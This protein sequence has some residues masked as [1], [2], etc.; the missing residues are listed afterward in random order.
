M[1][2]SRALCEKFGIVFERRHLHPPSHRAIF[3]DIEILGKTDYNKYSTSV[4]IESKDKPWRHST[5]KR[6]EIITE[7]AIR[8]LDA[9][10]NE[11][12]WRL[13]LEPEILSRFE[14][15]VTCIRCRA[16]LWRSELEAALTV[17]DT[18][19]P[20][21][22]E[23]RERRG[24]CS[25]PVQAKG[26]ER[27]D[28]GLNSI[29]DDRADELI[30]HDPEI[31]SQLPG[32][33]KPDRVYGFR[34]TARFKRLLY[35]T[36]SSSGTLI[37]ESVKHSPFPNKN[38]NEPLLF[39]FLV[40]EA[41]SE[42]GNGSFTQ[43][44]TQTAFTIRTLLDLQY[45][46]KKASGPGSQW[47][48]EP[49]VWFIGY[50]GEYWRISAAYVDDQVV[51]H[52]FRIIDGL[53]DGR[54]TKEEDSLR[55][56]LIMDYIFDW[57][58]D[59]H[60]RDI[61]EGLISLAET[62]APSLANETDVFSTAD[63]SDFT[64]LNLEPLEPEMA[65]ASLATSIEMNKA[66]SFF[67]GHGYAIR[68]GRHMHHTFYGLEV[69]VDNVREILQL[70]KSP[71]KKKEV[72][73]ALRI[74]SNHHD[75]IRVSRSCIDTIES[76]W[77]GCDRAYTSSENPLE[78]LQ[79][80]MMFTSFLGDRGHGLGREDPTVWDHYHEL[81]IVAV[82]DSA[83]DI[84]G[85]TPKR[86]P[87][88]DE[89]GLIRLVQEIK[90]AQVVEKLE[91]AATCWSQSISH[92]ALPR[93]FS[94]ASVDGNITP[95]VG[96][97]G[98]EAILKP[99]QAQGLRLPLKTY[100]SLR[101]GHLQHEASFMRVSRSSDGPEISKTSTHKL[102]NSTLET[103]GNWGFL[104]VVKV[105]SVAGSDVFKKRC[106]YLLDSSS[107]M[108]SQNESHEKDLHILD[109]GRALE[110]E[111]RNDPIPTKIYANLANLKRKV[112]A[113]TLDSNFAHFYTNAILLSS[114]LKR[115]TCQNQDNDGQ[116]E[117][118]QAR[119]D[120]M[121]SDPKWPYSFQETIHSVYQIGRTYGIETIL[122]GMK[123]VM[124][125]E[126]TLDESAYSVEKPCAGGSFEKP[127]DV[128]ALTSGGSFEEPIDVDALTIENGE[129]STPSQT[130]SLPRTM[131]SLGRRRSSSDG[132]VVLDLKTKSG[133]SP[134]A[135]SNKRRRK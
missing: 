39:P 68:D 85:E 45:G 20:S 35:C 52:R 132:M 4:T 97:I 28:S 101:T 13:A 93:E 116:E 88:V 109:Q 65:E 32:R 119:Y 46:L 37:G 120:Q 12:G 91:A 96:A 117:L 87:Q 41:K 29:F 72:M 16:R 64:L 34:A 9:N 86:G 23:R 26:D 84:F 40:L 67:D 5:K 47:K 6:A 74:A 61:I 123:E 131:Q 81:T 94:V 106:F 104:L 59:V 83:V 110:I 31:A 69:T 111:A 90:N 33:Q 124:V 126:E 76:I 17:S 8:C 133:N 130:Y 18:A 22:A 25:C 19:R 73:K 107:P 98:N 125:D 30:N 108:L 11:M 49:L 14:V 75:S 134:W 50:K 102:S 2:P 55:L 60:R 36:L 99:S 66:L 51:P 15:E 3:D 71:A 56:L 135:G 129:Q 89:E 58:R 77:T 1:A 80:R 92:K 63:P 113:P 38:N 121:H 21:L 54:L 24:V 114:G 78:M 7:K 127:I 43:I 95:C 57:A 118:A 10:K 128:D 70:A 103:S 100:Q 115:L 79:L 105:R 122:D 42:R 53:W 82:A 48:A 62:V 27:F 44:E 112:V